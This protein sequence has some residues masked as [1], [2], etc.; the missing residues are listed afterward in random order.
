MVMTWSMM[1]RSKIA[2]RNV[3]YFRTDRE[4]SRGLRLPSKS[5][6]SAETS[7]TQAC[8]VEAT[9]LLILMRPKHGRKLLSRFDR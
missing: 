5:S 2:C 4:L 6:T 1:A 9:I 3:W 7:L 8:T